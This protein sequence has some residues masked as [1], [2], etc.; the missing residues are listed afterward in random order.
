ML[1]NCM[2]GWPTLFRRP[3]I[4][5]KT[6]SPIWRKAILWLI[7]IVISVNP[8]FAQDPPEFQF[9]ILRSTDSVV[10]WLNLSPLLNAV[11]VGRMHDGLDLAVV[12]DLKL[13]RPRHLFGATTVADQQRRIEASYQ[14]LT[15]QYRL[16]S[17][18]GKIARKV[19]P[20][21]S[22]LFDYLADSILIRLADLDSL[23]QEER[24]RL[25][26]RIT[27]ISLGDKDIESSEELLS[28][29]DSPLR[30][31]YVQLLKITGYGRTEHSFQSRSFGTS[32]LYPL[33]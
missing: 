9:D 14:I 30:W 16:E 17:A 22:G 26:A 13:V 28:Q 18:N 8:V 2:S 11:N 7:A 27:T 29:G 4:R 19:F 15:E 6:I 10:V 20:S 21:Q 24:Y 5:L 3:F 33:R 31:L 12:C 23:D 25:E 32:E 1:S